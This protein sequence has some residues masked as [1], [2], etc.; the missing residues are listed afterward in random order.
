MPALP[1]PAT[2][3]LTSTK[4]QRQVVT[5]PNSP[6]Y[7]RPESVD[8]LPDLDLLTDLLAGTR[9]MHERAPWYIRRWTNEAD[10][11]YAIRATCED[12]Y[13]GVGRVISASVGMMFA[14]PPVLSFPT[15][16]VEDV[17]TPHWQ[18]L[19]AA[20]TAGNVWVKRFAQWAVRDGLAI[21]LVDHPPAPS[22][23][24]TR[25]DAARLSLRPTWA[26]YRRRDVL[27]WRTETLENTET[28]TMLALLE[29][30]TVA[31]GAFGVSERVYV[32]VLEL[33]EGVAT[34]RLLDVTD[35]QEGVEVDAGVFRSRSG[36]FTRLPIAVAY[37]SDPEAPFVCRPPLMGVAWAN[38]S[39]YQLS[40]E[41][42]FYTDLSSFPQPT[43]IGTMAADP[44]T[45]QPQQLNMGPLVGVQ[46]TEGSDFRWTE[47]A[48]T[49]FQNLD[50][51]VRSKLEQMA[52]LGLSFLSGDKRA[53]ETAEARRMDAT[54]ENSTLA[55]AAQGI[56]DAVN[57]ALEFHAEYLG[58]ARQDSPTISISREYDSTAMDPQTMVAFANLINAGLPLVEAVK[59]LQAGGR[60][61]GTRDPM[62]LAM[63]WAAGQAFAEAA[64]E[65]LSTQD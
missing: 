11:V 47:I 28:I 12:V 2:N 1:N 13:E 23:T 40:S 51:Q 6:L 20:G 38:L 5:D 62:E 55:T 43:V 31:D 15:D 4:V 33:V 17:V 52:A 48:G 45:G 64:P 8:A 19:D 7:R 61:D 57:L 58:V 37:T 42:R 30:T 50:N 16:G 53:Q 59:A 56:E 10:G 32:R 22:G 27:S 49:S 3:T 41:R 21:I 65:N 29:P 14:K 26:M 60:L 34:W 9:R 18:N 46:V 63:E 35:S 44:V 36:P 39:H 25:A 54:A 24:V